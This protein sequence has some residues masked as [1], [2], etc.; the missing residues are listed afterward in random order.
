MVIP[1][2]AGVS[3]NC[4]QFNVAVSNG[5]NGGGLTSSGAIYFSFQLQNRCGFNKPSISSE[6]SYVAGQKII[7]TIPETARQP[8]WDVHYFV[9]SAG[10]SSDPSTHVTICRS[11]GYEFGTGYDPQTTL[12]QL[13]ATIELAKDS[14]IALAPNVAT[15]QNLPTGN[16]RLD[17][18]VRWVVSESK[19]FEYRADSSLPIDSNTI[20]ADV[21][22]WVRIGSASAYVEDPISNAVGA[23]QNILKVNPT[24]T[25][26]TPPYPGVNIHKF[27]PSWEAKYWLYNDDSNPLPAGT[28]FGIELE[29]NNKRSPNLLSGLFLIKFNGFIKSDG[30]I[31]TTD[32]DGRYFPNLGA[33]IPWI[34]Q[35]ETPFVTI[36]PL[37]PGEAISIS[38]KPFFSVAELNNEVSSKSVIGI[39]PVIRTESGDYN[40]LGKLLMGDEADLSR[41]GIVYDIADKYRV[42]PNLGLVYDVLEGQAIVASYDFRTKPR[43]SYGNLLPNTANQKVIINGNGAVFTE[44]STYT[45]SASEAIRAFIGTIEGESAVGTFSSYTTGR[46]FRLQINFPTSIR[47]DYPDV[48]A[49]NTKA[50]FNAPSINIYAQRQDTSEIRKF[51]GY[52]IIAGNTS[53]ISIELLDWGNG[54]VVDSLP[55]PASNFSLFKPGTITTTTLNGNFPATQF[56]FAYSLV[57]TGRQITTTDHL[58]PECIREWEGDLQPPSI[59]VNP[60][61]TILDE[62][63]TPTVIN[64]GTGNQAYLT[65]SFPP[66]KSSVNFAQILT[67]S[68]SDILVDSNGNILS[69]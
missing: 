24:S 54:S 17:G 28:E 15:L 49:G 1:R 68:N 65:F 47:S 29:Y 56:R 4:P 34:P 8:G 62:G 53:P 19:F 45:P 6:I 12:T 25:I 39:L 51:P 21:G 58:H 59:S 37:Q 11:A 13:P 5:G 36:E 7:I 64:T 16:D 20:T 14:H 57:Y 55:A 38:V 60:V 43:R 26:P 27:M 22:Q 2:Y 35:L 44:L 31:K 18:Q 63:D 32:S 61:I 30:T 9:I 52:L 41:R 33:F 67:D 3:Y 48:V 46:G 66:I 42:V 69:L 50:K 23:H 40:P 10:T